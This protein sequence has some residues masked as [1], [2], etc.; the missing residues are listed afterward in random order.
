[1]VKFVMNQEY[2]PKAMNRVLTVPNL[3]S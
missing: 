1:M 3:I 2:S